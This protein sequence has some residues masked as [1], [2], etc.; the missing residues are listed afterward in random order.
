VDDISYTVS[1]KTSDTTSLY[2]P[3]GGI[4]YTEA[5][6]PTKQISLSVYANG[7][8]YNDAGSEVIGNWFCSVNSPPPAPGAPPAAPYASVKY[9][10]ALVDSF[11][12]KRV[13]GYDAYAC[14][15]LLNDQTAAP[16]NCTSAEMKVSSR[17]KTATS[18]NDT[19]VT[20]RAMETV[21]SPNGLSA[22]GEPLGPGVNTRNTKGGYLYADAGQS[23]V[24]IVVECGKRFEFVASS[25]TWTKAVTDFEP[26]APK[27]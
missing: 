6:L 2:A 9:S 17:I 15:V 14:G 11:T 23:T 22:A 18:P 16:K 27:P 21:R 12:L 24:M 7:P 3:S 1:L 13:L 4:T 25:I 5:K 20:S 26:S 19:V 10:G 8:Y